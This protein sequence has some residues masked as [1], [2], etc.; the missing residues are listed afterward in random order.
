MCFEVSWKWIVAIAFAIA[1]IFGA[2]GCKTAP[3]TA[4]QVQA[5]R[6]Q[7]QSWAE[8]MQKVGGEGQAVADL[9]SQPAALIEGFELPVDIDV[10]LAAQI[11]PIKAQLFQALLDTLEHQRALLDKLTEPVPE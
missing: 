2:T 5:H 9:E 4:E 8:F 7:I 3:L 6:E 10:Q 11:D 1:T